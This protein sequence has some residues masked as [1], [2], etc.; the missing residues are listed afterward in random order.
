M[1]LHWT[2]IKSKTYATMPE[3]MTERTTKII[4]ALIFAG[5]ILASKLLATG[6]KEILWFVVI[7]TLLFYGHALG[8]ACFPQKNWKISILP[9]VILFLA[10]QSIIQ[11][12]WYYLGGRLSTLSDAVTLIISVVLAASLSWR[13]PIWHIESSKTSSLE[14]APL[15]PDAR[16]IRYA[17]FLSAAA[18]TGA[19]FLTL[20]FIMRRAGQASTLE[21]ISTPWPLL[22]EYTLM[23]IA[24]IWFALIIIVAFTRHS[25]AAALTSACAIFSLTS[26]PPLI[27]RIGYGFDGFLHLASEKIILASGTLSPKPFYYIGQYV[28]TTWLSR[29][30]DMPVAT[31][32]RWL[33]PA[34]AAILL[35][36]TL[37]LLDGFNQRHDPAR[38]LILGLLPLSTFITT[39][40]QNFAYLLGLCAL[41]FSLGRARQTINPAAPIILLL[42]AM[43]IHPLAGLPMLIV[44]TALILSSCQ[45]RISRILSWFCVC[46]A[47]IAVPAMF[48]ILGFHGNITLIWN[49]KMI[50]NADVWLNWLKEFTPWIGN[51]AVIWPAWASL[52]S[53][54][55]PLIL[56]AAAV[57]RAFFKRQNPLSSSSE[58]HAAASRRMSCLLIAA[59]VILMASSAILKHI[60]EFT[61]LIDY[62]RGN[63]ADR[64]N[65]LAVF[66][67]LPPAMLG[68]MNF[69]HRAKN[70]PKILSAGV[71]IFFLGITAALAYNSL[72]RHD[73]LAAGRGWSTSRHD[74]EAVKL[75]D[76][77]AGNRPYTVL[78]N[79]SVSA[80]AVAAL[81][82]KRYAQDIFFYP[83]PTGGALYQ[84]FLDISRGEPSMDVIQDTAALGQSDLVYVVINDYWWRTDD[85]TQAMRKIANQKWEIGDGRVKIYKFDLSMD[86]NSSATTSAL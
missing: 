27:Y 79:Q 3:A 80:A 86:S 7:F 25:M 85:I 68:L 10:L 78:A 37:L 28:F 60:S 84:N 65:T 45:R 8:R 1:G 39:T 22:P 46:L 83:I 4:A 53:K 81:G 5:A 14:S 40:P 18:L 74:F 19:S 29:L 11:T 61:F 34:G 48:Y 31:I 71:I 52:T 12:I 54:I 57:P 2:I 36:I 50:F 16:L 76:E 56:F 73:A 20:I 69:W 13:I 58:H 44:A 55:L 35:P 64:L 17:R 43:A 59:A 32:D 63:Y 15:A 9:G 62:E 24:L 41:F 82:F 66:C 21:S 26:I 47:G 42:W 70:A 33:V 30:A 49:L 67:L 23:L 75:I 6:V 51:H 77:D 38:F 72:P